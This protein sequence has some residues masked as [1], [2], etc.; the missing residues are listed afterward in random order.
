MSDAAIQGPSRGATW[1]PKGAEGDTNSGDEDKVKVEQG[2]DGGGANV[3]EPPDGE[4]S[5]GDSVVPVTWLAAGTGLVAL[6]LFTLQQSLR[7]AS[8]YGIE[9]VLG[10]SDRV[11]VD[12]AVRL[13]CEGPLRWGIGAAY[14]MLDTALFMPFYAVLILLIVTRLEQAMR[15]GESRLI[16]L[17]RTEVWRFSLLMVLALAAVLVL[18][19]V[20][21][22]ENYG[23]ALR[24]GLSAP[25]FFGCV[26][27]ALALGTSLWIWSA[28]WMPDR[29][30]LLKLLALAATV[31]AFVLV[32]WQAAYA[33]AICKAVGAMAGDPSLAWAHFAKPLVIGVA[34]LPPLMAVLIWWFGAELARGSQDAARRARAAMRAGAAGVVGRSRYVLLAL[35]LF[36]VVTLVMDQCRDVLLALAE[37]TPSL[38]LDS[39]K[40][41]WRLAVLALGAL[42]AGLFVYSCWLWTRLAGMVE[43]PGIVMP[44]TATV[45][46]WAAEAQAWIGGFARGWARTLSI[47]PLVMLCA[48]TAYAVGDAFSAVAVQRD[49]ELG[50]Q[51]WTVGMLLLFGGGS[52]GIGAVFLWWRRKL[53]LRDVGLYYNSEAN[54]HALL[55]GSARAVLAR[56]DERM[57]E[58]DFAAQRRMQR[59]A[60]A[61]RWLGWLLL[62]RVLPLVALA[63]LLLLRWV[64][65]LAPDAAA[66]APAT[67][68]LVT[69]ALCWW[70]AVFGGI[71]L[72]EQRQA[73]PWILLL[74]VLIGALSA[75][76][77]TNNHVLP[78]P[79]SGNS[80][81]A[82]W[83]LQHA[84]GSLR[85]D[86]ALVVTALAVLGG[87]LWW[88]YTQDLS[89]GVY[90]PWWWRWQRLL[91]T[92]AVMGL[93]LGALHWADRS[94]GV[95]EGR[96]PGEGVVA[97]PTKVMPPNLEAA[98]AEFL[99]TLP[100]PADPADLS[101][102]RV[103][104]VASEGGGIRSAYWT[105]Q[106][107]L[108]L[109]TEVPNFD[110]RTFVLSGVSG[111]AVGEAVY[112]ACLRDPEKRE[113][114]ACIRDRFDKLDALS[115]LLGALMFEDAFARV[116][117]V[118]MG[119]GWF[120]CRNPGCGH[121]NRAL[122][123]EREW[124]RI[125]PALAEPLATSQGPHLILNS[126]WVESGSRAV[127]SSLDLQS[128]DV[129]SAEI[130]Q[131]RL[132]AGISLI[133]AAHV[134]A[135]FPFSNPLAAVQPARSASSD[136]KMVGHLADGGYFDN[137]GT[138][139]LS[140]VWRALGP[141][142]AAAK[143][144]WHPQVILIRNGQKKPDCEQPSHKG[145]DPVC[146]DRNRKNL[147]DAADLDRP[148]DK[149]RMD[150]YA[151][152]LGP[153]VALVNVSGIGAHGRQAPAALRAQLGETTL[154]CRNARVAIMDQIEDGSLVPLGWYLSRPARAALDHQAAEVKLLPDCK[155]AW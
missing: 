87:G 74:I 10:W 107:L 22:L 19:V 40:S 30:A 106:V 36:G 148:A 115:P 140:D 147:P 133:T 61:R 75:V 73:R 32:A 119:E 132:G 58:A 130:V 154:T 39:W 45:G 34:L 37:P 44:G 120:R 67:L 123:F 25:L 12:A 66:Q 109:H 111:G 139:S 65:A 105:A 94:A 14:V 50:R 142:L 104:L 46:S 56:D 96:G 90:K 53:G 121:L 69:L 82:G 100:E 97:A 17:R 144:G 98:I 23:G 124:V 63:L 86:G 64:M 4:S 57:R 52:V 20:D 26:A 6:L 116:L 85:F 2:R 99:A 51:L 92:V 43:R 89:S 47:A 18:L 15:R 81:P 62:P 138:T 71:S 79:G 11:S 135:R 78:L 7:L 112:R 8:G 126:T 155:P 35:A 80:P 141:K 149:R 59:Y 55:R 101:D 9:D 5:S 72:A 93:A 16:V 84:L 29:V 60:T 143:P 137:S 88:V 110:R 3:R 49:I 42:S 129:P 134:A 153:P 145:P 41:L 83:P 70:L 152:L 118:P 146:I 151:D 102:R 77:W 54:V 117:P 28:G 76:G 125:F 95:L 1:P 91:F 122:G 128:K 108:R 127:A 13:W 48:L 31:L 21:L 103:F 38:Q 33:D 136:G 27:C 113:L 24:L 131:A 114:H 150:L 68:A